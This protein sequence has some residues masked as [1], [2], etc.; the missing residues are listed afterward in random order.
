MEAS[1]SKGLFSRCVEDWRARGCPTPKVSGRESPSAASVE[2]NSSAVDEGL[3]PPA[4]DDVASSASSSAFAVDDNERA[5]SQPS[6]GRPRSEEVDSSS[7]RRKR[8][9]SASAAADDPAGQDEPSA[10]APCVSEAELEERI[11]LMFVEGAAGPAASGRGAAMPAPTKEL[12]LRV[13]A[14]R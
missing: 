12:V 11:A 6:G 13:S 14:L 2:L 7:V 4:A 10:P 8:T 9:A 1:L 3:Q 5:S